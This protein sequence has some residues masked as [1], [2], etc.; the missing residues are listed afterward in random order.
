[1]DIVALIAE[2][3][4]KEALE[5]GELEHLSGRGKPLVLE[6]FSEVP[7]HLRVSF[8]ILKNAGMLPVEMEVRKE[9]VQLRVQ[10]ANCQDAETQKRL[11]ASINAAE[12]KYHLLMEKHSRRPQKL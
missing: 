10:L 3:R 4:I 1:M 5:N 9:L 6:D 8:K 7:E 12:L 2:I 11:Q